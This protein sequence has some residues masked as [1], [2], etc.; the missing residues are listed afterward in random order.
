MRRSAVSAISKLAG[1]RGGHLPK[2]SDLR[3]NIVKV[4]CERA[5][6]V[7]RPVSRISTG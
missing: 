5:E 7:V 3:R 6:K 1:A 4:L 2:Q